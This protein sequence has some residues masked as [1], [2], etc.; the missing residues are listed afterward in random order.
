[1]GNDFC[2]TSR[3]LVITGLGYCSVWVGESPILQGLTPPLSPS[4]QAPWHRSPGT[5]TGPECLVSACAV[6]WKAG[7]GARGAGEAPSPVFRSLA[8]PSAL[9]SEHPLLREP[10]NKFHGHP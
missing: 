7:S 5:S 1:M 9:S 6:P 2:R 3:A 4:P 10:R 8:F